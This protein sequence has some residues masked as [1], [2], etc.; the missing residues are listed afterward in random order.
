MVT[1][2]K[3]AWNMTLRSRGD[4]IGVRA[5]LAP[6]KIGVPKQTSLLRQRHRVESD[7]IILCQVHVGHDGKDKECG[8]GS[9]PQYFTEQ[10]TIS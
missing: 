5:L 7:S 4:D 8:P 6:H 9:S 3:Y 1:K 2:P 10:V